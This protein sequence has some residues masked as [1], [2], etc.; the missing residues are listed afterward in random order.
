MKT[1][2]LVDSRRLK[3]RT[4]RIGTVRSNWVKRRMTVPSLSSAAKSNA[5]AWAIPSH[6]LLDETMLDETR[7][8]DEMD[9]CLLQ[10]PFVRVPD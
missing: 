5:G 7:N 4:A 3:G 10:G 8:Y 1:R 6:G 9:A 2:T